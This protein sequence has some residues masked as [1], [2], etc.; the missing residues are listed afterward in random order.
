MAA[1]SVLGAEMLRRD[2]GSRRTSWQ[3][4]KTRPRRH[5]WC[6]SISR[7][8]PMLIRGLTF[9]CRGFNSCRKTAPQPTNH[10]WGR[11]SRSSKPLRFASPQTPYPRGGSAFAEERYYSISVVAATGE[12]PLV[13]GGP[14]QLACNGCIVETGRRRTAAEGARTGAAP[15]A[16][17]NGV[18]LKISQDSEIFVYS[19]GESLANSS[20]R[21]GGPRNRTKC[22]KAE[23][24]RRQ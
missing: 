14:H 12:A 23:C 13:P 10:P 22:G 24:L 19:N 8:P 5:G 15:F 21:S 9:S 20:R 3:Q 11:P 4:R 1:P 17:K 2:I 16:S 7:C 18:T 6:K